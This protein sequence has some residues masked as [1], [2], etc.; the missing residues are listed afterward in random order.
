MRPRVQWYRL[1]GRRLQPAQDTPVL[2]GKLLTLRSTV[3]T[4]PVWVENQGVWTIEVPIDAC[5]P[6][7][8]LTPPRDGWTGGALSTVLLAMLT[9]DTFVGAWSCTGTGP[10]GRLKGPVVGGYVVSV[11]S[12]PS[13]TQRP[14][15]R[16]PVWRWA[17]GNQPSGGKP[18][19]TRRKTFASSLC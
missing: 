9:S 12:H 6:S 13:L 17:D 10:L 11:R 15:R 5:D 16:R 3:N 1:L 19:V 4:V 2:L 8:T 18:R 14:R 7:V